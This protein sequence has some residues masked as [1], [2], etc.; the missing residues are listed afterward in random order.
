MEVHV[1]YATERHD[2]LEMKIRKIKSPIRAQRSSFPFAPS[3]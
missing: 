1:P 3:S 2:S